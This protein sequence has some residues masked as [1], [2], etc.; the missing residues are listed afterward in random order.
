MTEKCNCAEQGCVHEHESNCDCMKL[1]SEKLDKFLRFLVKKFKLDEKEATTIAIEIGIL[2]QEICINDYIG[3]LVEHEN[4]PDFYY[5]MIRKGETVKG[6]YKD[7]F[8]EDGL[9]G[10]QLFYW[11]FAQDQPMFYSITEEEHFENLA[12]D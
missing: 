11:E 1:T 4:L 10:Q 5:Q 2:K 7:Y 3:I 12:E 9:D 8:I 6:N